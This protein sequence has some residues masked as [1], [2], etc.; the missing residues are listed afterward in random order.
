MSSRE[1]ET[2]ASVDSDHRCQ[3]IGRGSHAM[4]FFFHSI[5]KFT[6]RATPTHI[7]KSSPSTFFKELVVANRLHNIPN[8]VNCIAYV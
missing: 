2:R 3:R 5:E 6:T 1:S 8:N 7:P 4:P